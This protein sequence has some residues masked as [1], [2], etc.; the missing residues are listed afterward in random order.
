M[1]FEHDSE[2]PIPPGDREV[3]NTDLTLTAPDANEFMAFA[4]RGSE[5]SPVGVIVLPDVRGLFQFYKDL[6][7]RFAQSGYD[8]V[9]IDYFGR[10][11]EER[12]RPNDWDFRPHVEKCT[13]EGVSADVGA[14]VAWLRDTNPDRSVFT[15]G[16]CFGGSHSWHQAAN[17]H[18]LAGAIG[19]Y[20]RP[21]RSETDSVIDRVGEMDCPVL[22][23]MGGDDPGIPIEDI[24]EFRRALVDAAVSHEIVVYPGAP[25]SFFDR[26]HAEFSEESS[27]AWEKVLVF[28]ESH[29]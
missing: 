17:G 15:V 23:I 9:A 11:A 18:G 21:R 26:K 29:L 2:P 4:S 8:A 19:F 5:E 12:D 6:A 7:I 1:C 20:G 22:A 3:V 16:F 14:A 28:I 27:D 13:V 25:H 10:T 24:E